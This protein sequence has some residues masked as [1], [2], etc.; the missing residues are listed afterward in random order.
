MI[1]FSKKNMFKK[2]FYN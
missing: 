1:N 2:V